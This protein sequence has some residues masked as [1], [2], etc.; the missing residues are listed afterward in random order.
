MHFSNSISKR[1]SNSIFIIGIISII[2]LFLTFF[3][4]PFKFD[5]VLAKEEVVISYA[6]NISSTHQFIV[7][8]F[9]EEYKGRIRV[10]TI[11][12][13]FEK[14]STNERKELL[15]RSLRSK[16]E[17][18]DI[19][20]VDLIWLARFAKWAEP[21]DKYIVENDT[22]S[23]LDQALESCIFGNHLVALPMYLD[24][25]VM[26]YRKDL[27]KKI[28][29][30]PKIERKLKEGITWKD[31]ISLR[32]YFELD[33]NQFYIF[34]ADNYEGLVCSYI[35]ILQN[36]S[37]IAYSNSSF[38]I[39]TEEN[40]NTLELLHDLIYKYNM[41]PGVITE[42][43]ENNCYEYFIENDGVFLR[44]WPSSIRDFKN[45]SN[46]QNVDTLLG[47]AAL[48]Y[49]EG[50]RP[51]SVFGGWNLMLSKYSE[52]KKEAFEFIKFVLRKET[53]KI[54]YEN[55]SY[56][57]TLAEIYEDKNFIERYPDIINDKNLLNNGIHRPFLNNYT[58]FSD[59][60]SYYTNQVLK[61]NLTIEDALINTNKSL[62]SGELI[63]R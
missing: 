23:L 28:P 44:G 16:S 26:Y 42:F 53:Q 9:N 7:D 48:P 13:P 29:N 14:F 10:E 1:T 22:L 30:Y 27:L 3:L 49:I 6:D 52:N 58:K 61:G 46:L 51:R 38:K 25:G 62:S 57:P 55:G 24:I 21:L 2:I 59:V 8:K 20:A 35:E 56:L 54:L 34:P 19:F 4:L 33:K 18:L 50:S 41:S 40:K 47:K 39:V 31:F 15:I 36:N 11:D 32:K 5:N 60:I 17:K 37:P 63:L 45:L 12:L 43:N